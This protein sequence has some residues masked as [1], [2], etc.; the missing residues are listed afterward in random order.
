MSQDSSL[1]P[2]AILKSLGVS[3][4]RAVA[5]VTGG[6]DTALWR[7]EHN[8][9][10][11]AL[12]VFRPTQSAVYRRELAA[13]DIASKHGVPVPRVRAHEVWQ[14]RPVMLLSWG[15]GQ[16]LAL[17]LRRQPW[18]RVKLSRAFGQMQASIH[19]I[20]VST[21]PDTAPTDWILAA[22]R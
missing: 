2:Y 11:S 19:S 13:M 17:A 1:D 6:T 10:T 18:R 7:V 22:R 9:V 15:R 3:T 5:P 12:R 21:L 20:E 4:I 14:E 16:P 8:Q